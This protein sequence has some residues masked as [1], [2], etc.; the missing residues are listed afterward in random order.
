V[1]YVK[2]EVRVMVAAWVGNTR[3]IDNIAVE[4]E[5]RSSKAALRQGPVAVILAAGEGKRMK[6]GLPK[7]LHTIGGRP[8]VAQVVRAV[9]EA[10][11][12]Q[13]VAVVGHGADRVGPVV[14]KL[15]VATAMQD[16]QRGTGH[17]VLQALP[18]V[19]GRTGDILVLSGDT[20][21]L[22]ASTIKRILAAHREHSNAIT[23]G[24]AVVPDPGGYGRVVRDRTGAF[25]RIVEHRDADPALRAITEVNGGIYCFKASALFDSLLLLTADNAQME[26]YITEAIDIVKARGGRVEAILVD[27]HTEL[28]GVNTPQELA[29]VRKLFRRRSR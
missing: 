15:G 10:G 24:T 25:A 13:A 4:A 7:V 29:L 26:Y 11:V 14:R 21:L 22:R 17:A 9:R 2:S 28:L 12:K 6:S 3:L 16:V 19:S 8:M 18:L 1:S 23:F 20:P 5:A 27:D